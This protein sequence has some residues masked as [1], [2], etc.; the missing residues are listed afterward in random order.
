MHLTAAHIHNGIQVKGEEFNRRDWTLDTKD[1]FTIASLSS[2]HIIIHSNKRPT[3]LMDKCHFTTMHK[4]HK[5]MND[6]QA[7][8]MK[9]SCQ[10]MPHC[11]GLQD[12]GGGLYSIIT[13]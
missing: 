10:C 9:N 13:C 8:G 5:L 7:H 1:H 12:A 2:A 6:S 11:P 4:P 3:V